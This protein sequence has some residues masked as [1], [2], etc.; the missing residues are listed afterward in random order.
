MGQDPD[1]H[2]VRACGMEMHLE[3][4]QKPMY[5][6]IDWQN[7]ADQNR[8]THFMRACAVDMHLKISQPPL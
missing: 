8:D 7:A 4:S 6:E 2:F 5:T 1:T 3:I